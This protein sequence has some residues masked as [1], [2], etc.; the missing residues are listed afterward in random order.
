MQYLQLLHFAA[1]R[2]LYASLMEKGGHTLYFGIEMF[3]FS[4]SVTVLATWR[5]Q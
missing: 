1:T 3:K 2:A 5:L 4:A